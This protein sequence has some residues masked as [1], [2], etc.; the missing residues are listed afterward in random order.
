MGDSAGSG[1]SA[2]GSAVAQL[3]E[4]ARASKPPPRVS[5]ASHRP[6]PDS[7]LRRVVAFYALTCA[8]S[9]G[10]SFALLALGETVH[11]GSGWPTHFPAFAGP[12]IA[13]LAV[14]A[15]STGR[16]G[17][18]ALARRI[19][20]WRFNLFWWTAALSPLAYL[21]VGLA[22]AAATGSLPSAHQFA[23]YSGWPTLGIAGTAL[24]VFLNGLGEET[25][26]RGYL[27][28][29]L[30]PR[31]GARQ[32]AFII[33]ALWAFWHLPLFFL[34]ASYRTIAPFAVVGF[35]IGILSGSVVAT[36]LYYGTRQSVLAVAIWH[37]SYNM[38]AATAASS[39]TVAAVASALIILQAALLIR[40]HE[41]AQ[42]HG[43]PPVLGPPASTHAL[44]P[45]AAQ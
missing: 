19:V 13:A 7:T 29:T 41:H 45:P 15:W 37:A 16:L 23:L 36:W 10:W 30:Q 35:G 40:R 44:Y 31:Y 27:L 26:W 43:L 2:G 8:I 12:L 21:A 34:L 9:W 28:P 14:T 6:G 20:R 39:G 33:G 38:A 5:A 11:Q 25:G 18:V 42:R 24:A 22:V 17:V 4:T 1:G 3:R 32:S